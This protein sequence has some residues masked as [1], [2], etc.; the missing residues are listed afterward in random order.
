M[1]IFAHRGASKAAPENT[2]KA[3]R[4]AFEQHADGIEFDTYQHDGG[5]VVFHDRTL[6]RRA[7]EPGYLLDASW[8][9]LRVLRADGLLPDRPFFAHALVA[10]LI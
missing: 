7:R 3:F 2:L 8:Q 9:A 5:I 1:L 10:I 6:K 4:L